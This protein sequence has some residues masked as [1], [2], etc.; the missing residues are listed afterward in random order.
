MWVPIPY[1][2]IPEALG[3]RYTSTTYGH[4]GKS[5]IIKYIVVFHFGFELPN[6]F[7]GH[8]GLK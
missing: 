4:S 3:N 5:F 1:P 2:L 7:S 8:P 6:V